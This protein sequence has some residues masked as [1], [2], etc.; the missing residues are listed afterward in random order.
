MKLRK[1]LDLFDRCVAPFRRIMGL[2]A[3][4]G[5]PVDGVIIRY[6][7]SRRYLRKQHRCHD[8]HGILTVKKRQIVVNSNSPEAEAYD[9]NCV[10]TYLVGD[11][12]FV[13]L[14]FQCAECGAEYEVRELKRLEKKVRQRGI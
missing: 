1:K 11:I 6:D 8:C 4:D 3:D 10:D 5:S 9:F 2:T 14:Y 12:N 7:H 13:T